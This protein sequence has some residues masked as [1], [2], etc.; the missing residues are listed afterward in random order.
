MNNLI[1]PQTKKKGTARRREPDLCGVVYKCDYSQADA[2]TD[3]GDSIDFR[4]ITTP[5]INLWFPAGT[6]LLVRGW[7]VAIIIILILCIIYI[8]YKLIYNINIDT[9]DLVAT[10]Q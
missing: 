10:Y 9:S 1:N 5:S 2:G 6:V 8:S 3:L 4:W 7:K